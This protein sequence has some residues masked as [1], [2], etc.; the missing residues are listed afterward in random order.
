MST[1]APASES[2]TPAVRR[3]PRTGYLATPLTTDERRFTA[4]MYQEHQGLVRMM[5]GKMCRKYPSVSSDDI[6]SCIDI[7]FVKTCRA[8]D[9]AKGKFS[10]LLGVF[11]EGEIRHYIRDHNWSIKAPASMRSLGLRAR[12]MIRAGASKHDVCAQLSISTDTLKLALFSIQSL[13]HETQGFRRHLCPRPTPWETLEA[14][15]A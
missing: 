12:Y 3:R 11:C 4:R 8:W 13:S 1:A 2:P 7:A 15:E 6:F 9:A 14:G 5:G 10:T